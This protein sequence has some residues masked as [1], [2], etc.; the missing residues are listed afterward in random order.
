[1]MIDTGSLRMLDAKLEARAELLCDAARSLQELSDDEREE[2]RVRVLTFMRHEVG[3]HILLD[4]HVLY[5]KI[6]ER[7]GDP[8]ATA[9]LHYDHSALGWWVDRLEAADLRDTSELQR[10]LYGLHALIRLHLSKEEDLYLDA[11]DANA[12]PAGC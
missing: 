2:M 3:E 12:W 8:L 1:M 10:L 11:M 5:P 4:K 7:L 9:P 6:V